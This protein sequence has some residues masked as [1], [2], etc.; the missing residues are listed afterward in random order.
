MSVTPGEEACCQAR[1]SRPPS[2]TVGVVA[3]EGD[4]GE[5]LGRVL[6]QPGSSRSAAESSTAPGG[7]GL[8][9][10]RLSGVADLGPHGRLGKWWTKIYGAGPEVSSITFL[11]LFSQDSERQ[12]EMG[13][14][15]S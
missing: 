14:G 7:G 12:G 15:R 8:Q 1:P 3:P 9:H 13:V 5:E 10:S 11:H 4:V 2:C 6:R